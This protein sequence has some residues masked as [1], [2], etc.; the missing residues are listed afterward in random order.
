M[1]QNTIFFLLVIL[2][3]VFPLIFG[4]NKEFSGTDGAALEMIEKI[5]PVYQP[6][7]SNLWEPSSGEVES[8]LFALQAAS[9]AAFIGYAFGYAKARFL[10]KG[11]D[12]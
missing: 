8:L 10:Y 1:K 9:G 11:K 4:T 6:W 2:I 5:N 7:F 12:R 3:I